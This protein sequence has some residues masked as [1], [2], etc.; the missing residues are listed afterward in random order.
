MQFASPFNLSE[1]YHLFKKSEGGFKILESL[2]SWKF[3]LQDPYVPKLVL[4][5]YNFAIFQHIFCKTFDESL[6][7]QA[8][9]KY[10]FK[11]KRKK[12]AHFWTGKCAFLI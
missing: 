3:I 11:G 2:K 5:Y 8:E 4:K 12:N 1:I 9:F 7:K 6:Q 10:I